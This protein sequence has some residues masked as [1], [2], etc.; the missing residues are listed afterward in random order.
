M[1]NTGI[2]G[3]VMV[4]A[5]STALICTDQPGATPARPRSAQAPLAPAAGA[6]SMVRQAAP[7]TGAP[8]AGGPTAGTDPG[9]ASASPA[10]LPGPVP[11]AGTTPAFGLIEPGSG[12][13]GL[14]FAAARRSQPGGP[15]TLR[16]VDVG[17]YRP[18]RLAPGAQLWVT[19]PL[20]SGTPPNVVQ[21][22]Q[23]TPARFAA[24]YRTVNARFGPILDR[25]HMFDVRLDTKG[26]IAWIHQ[27]FTP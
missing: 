20:Y 12:E 25:A 19:V 7:A 14:L 18:M 1:R 21:G 27:M 23:V 17:R 16:P 10:P 4:V 22:V 8:A 5:G 2:A 13:T 24:L 3:A 15:E 6:P 11:P 26:R 9:P